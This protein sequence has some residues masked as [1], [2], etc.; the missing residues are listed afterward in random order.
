M[1]TADLSNLNEFKAKYLADEN[2]QVRLKAIRKLISHSKVLGPDRTCEEIIPIL[3]EQERKDEEAILSLIGTEIESTL[4]NFL[5]KEDL[6]YVL[7]QI[8]QDLCVFELD[9]DTPISER[10]VIKALQKIE[11]VFPPHILIND[12]FPL[13]KK[14]SEET[15]THA[16]AGSVFLIPT[17][18]E[19]SPLIKRK[20]L[21]DIL[22]A[23]SGDT[24]SVVRKSVAAVI[25]TIAQIA[26]PEVT[27]SDFLSI[28]YTLAR[29]PAVN[30]RA[31]SVDSVTAVAGLFGS[32]E[33]G[34]LF[35]EQE[36]K[37]M[38]DP[39]WLVR[40]KTVKNAPDMARIF[41]STAEDNNC[42]IEFL[43]T[44]LYVMEA[45]AEL[46]VRAAATSALLPISRGLDPYVINGYITPVVARMVADPSIEV[47]TN[48]AAAAPVLATL[49]PK[50]SALEFTN[51]T[52]CHLL[53]ESSVP[54]LLA[55]LGGIPELLPMV[56]AAPVTAAVMRLADSK[57]WRV[58]RSVIALLPT[59]IAYFDLERFK[60]K[61]AVLIA[62]WLNDSNYS[63]R[64]FTL[65]N[66]GFY[67]NVFGQDWLIEN[68]IPTLLS[69][70]THNNYLFR[71]NTLY[72]VSSL[73]KVLPTS[74]VTNTFLPIVL[75]MS[76]DSVPNIRFNVAKTLQA[77]V[78]FLDPAVVESRVIPVLERLVKD[79]DMDV[80]NYASK[81]M[82][83]SKKKTAMI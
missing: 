67:K 40:Q 26:G 37:F 61:V 16:R 23:L 70:S 58:K 8:L 11:L 22:I 41:S 39:S 12:L 48:I 72:G 43:G 19:R 17:A 75:R 49:I 50:E 4:L 46:D 25:G 24:S 69:F 57:E 79:K 44:F 1:E 68:I 34:K 29:D 65:R 76:Q 2:V 27:K 71:V 74:V 28:L 31:A 6:T 36:Y 54:V 35:A 53:G 32:V 64:E 82:E 33:A 59:L 45:D 77:M 20:E 83:V 5:G 56:G 30:V 62:C 52:V 3:E 66:L 51:D 9:E 7:L 38:I 81:C 73:S 18:Y 15:M 78:P 13:I 60:E 55:V 42:L 14:L 47:L 10:S 80:R 63:I 21:K